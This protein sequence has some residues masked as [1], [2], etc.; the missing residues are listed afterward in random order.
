MRYDIYTA[1]TEEFLEFDTSCLERKILKSMLS[2]ELER[3]VAHIS[4]NNVEFDTR[5]ES[6]EI[7]FIAQAINLGDDSDYKDAISISAA[8]DNGASLISSEEIVGMDIEERKLCYSCVE[9]IG[10]V[11]NTL[12]IAGTVTYDGNVEPRSVKLGSWIYDTKIVKEYKPLAD[13]CRT[14]LD[15]IDTF[16][17]LEEIQENLRKN[18][19]IRPENYV[20]ATIYGKFDSQ[21][22]TIDNDGEIEPLETYKNA[23]GKKFSN[24]TD[25]YKDPKTI[26][27][28]LHSISDF[29]CID[30]CDRLLYGKFSAKDFIETIQK[31]QTQEEFQMKPEVEDEKPKQFQKESTKKQNY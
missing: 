3:K 31:L 2:A 25:F 30:V 21:A 12:I 1:L 16:A 22:L 18:Q 6:G 15:T 5:E 19:F 11:E 26:L 8:S 20:T 9:I 4:K 17:K 14:H 7:E 24:C 29:L 13:F 28:K 27:R 23:F 10:N